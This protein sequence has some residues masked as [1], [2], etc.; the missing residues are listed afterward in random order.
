MKTNVLSAQSTSTFSEDAHTYWCDRFSKLKGE[1]TRF[2]TSKGDR[3]DIFI[4]YDFAEVFKN[5]SV[6]L[7]FP[8]EQVVENQNFSPAEISILADLTE[9]K[10][11]FFEKQ[12]LEDYIPRIEEHIRYISKMFGSGYV[13]HLTE[14][15]DAE[16]FGSFSQKCLQIKELEECFLID[17]ADKTLLTKTNRNK[18]GYRSVSIS[19][20]E[21]LKGCEIG[22]NSLE[23]LED[24]LSEISATIQYSPKIFL[25]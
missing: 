5:S 11:E 20:L 12:Y 25:T 24:M 8:F 14:I 4:T 18:Y 23:F 7:D 1:Y 3:I 15:I 22:M 10:D 6:K 2:Y 16:V 13:S 21:N 19:E 17:V 9:F